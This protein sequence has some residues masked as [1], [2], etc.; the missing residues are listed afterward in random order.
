MNFNGKTALITGAARG[1]GKTIAEKLASLG[2]KVAISDILIDLAMQTVDELK[3]KGYQ[4]L[5]IK[6]DVV[7]SGEVKEMI[8]KVMS[9]FG[10]IDIVV[11]NAGIT[12]DALLLRMKEEDWDLVIN[13]NL[14]GTFLVMQAAAKKMIKQRSG[15]IINISSAVGRMGNP[16]QAN[17]VA[18]KAGVIGL[19]RTAARELGGRGITVNAIAPGFITTDMTRDLP[20][21]VMDNLL[22]MTPLKRLGSPEDV[23]AAVA[24]LASDEGGYLTGQVIGVDGG[25][26]M[27]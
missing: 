25:M 9:E 8:E 21:T 12:R 1:I 16:G 7:N 3:S 11:N 4:A 24:Y 26:T 27:Y 2:A 15:R 20:E 17:Y 22:A 14:K 19:T 23:A 18:S 6:A 5:A 10:S 13:I